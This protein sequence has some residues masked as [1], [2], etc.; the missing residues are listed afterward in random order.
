VYAAKLH[1][2]RLASLVGE[3]LLA[4]RLGREAEALRETF[5]QRYWMEDC[6][7]YALALDGNKQPCRVVT[8]NAGH[9]LFCGTATPERAACVAQ[10][11]MTRDLFCGWGVR[12]VASSET[13]YNPVS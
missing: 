5:E 3:P 1:G 8:S 6:G 11:L 2:S 4:E 12:T 9:A 10:K 13:R 7:Y